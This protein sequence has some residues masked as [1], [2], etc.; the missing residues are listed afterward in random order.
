MTAKMSGKQQVVEGFDLARFAG[1]GE[2]EATPADLPKRRLGRPK[3]TEALSERVQVKITKREFDTLK[4]KA[5]MVPLSKW[6]RAQ[7][8]EQRVI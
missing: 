6:L 8:K 7:L 1:A 4:E 3:S 5:G 2:P